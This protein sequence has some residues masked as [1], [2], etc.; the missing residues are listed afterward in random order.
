MQRLNIHAYRLEFQSKFTEIEGSPFTVQLNPSSYTQDFRVEYVTEQA[1]GTSSLS[2]G[3]HFHDPQKISFDFLFDATGAI[4]STRSLEEFQ[5]EGVHKE[6]EKFKKF[7][8]KYT[9][10]IHRPNFLKLVWG[11]LSFDCVLEEMS[12]EYTLFNAEGI[13]LRANVKATFRE[14]IEEEL[15][16]PIEN[17]SSPDVT[18]YRQVIAGDNILNLAEEVYGDAHEYWRVVAANQ[19]VNFRNLKPGTALIFPAIDKR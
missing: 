1:A 7:V 18:H 3:Y 8:Y 15:R 2:Q 5:K 4:K 14:T 9:G 16:G 6:I 19:L 17:P 10:V 13:P 11:K 12:I